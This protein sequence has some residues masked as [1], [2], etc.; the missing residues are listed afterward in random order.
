M[1][2]Q[3]NDDSTRAKM[4]AQAEKVLCGVTGVKAPDVATRLNWQMGLTQ[5]ERGHSAGI[6]LGAG[7]QMLAEMNPGD[8]IASMLAIQM[9]GVHEAAL[10]RLGA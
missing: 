6:I 8:A 2:A 4:I 10:R 5:R 1:A 9:S 7:L 3:R